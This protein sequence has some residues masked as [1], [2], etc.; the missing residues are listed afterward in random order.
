MREAIVAEAL[1]QCYAALSY[2]DGWTTA[3]D[4]L[5]WSVG[6][7]GC[8][9]VN[10]TSPA[11]RLHL[12]ASPRYQDFVRDFVAEGWAFSDHRAQR[13]WPKLR[14][15]GKVLIEHDISTE[16]ERDNLPVYR[17]LYARHDLYWWATVSFVVDTDLWAL[18]FLRSQAA[19]PF[20]RAEAEQ[21][22]ALAPDLSRLVRLQRA[23]T[24]RKARD[25][26]QTLDG[27]AC[28]A[29]VVGPDLAV[30]TLN[31]TAEA[32]LEP[33]L[34]VRG[35]RLIAGRPEVEAALRQLQSQ[36]RQDAVRHTAGPIVINRDGSGR[37]LLIDVV[38]GSAAFGPNAP[39]QHALLVMQD[40]D[41]K[42]EADGQRM[43]LI[44][45][46][47]RTEALCAE[48]L[49]YGD[50]IQAAADHLGIARETARSHLKVLFAKTGTNRQ[51]DL[52]SLLA[53]AGTYR[54]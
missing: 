19:E 8:S 21:L 33:D 7:Q 24:L 40:L 29:M 5:A 12:P 36:I 34:K 51:A 14:G 45:G 20:S 37:P 6:A 46:F 32:C 16:W 39:G 23:L 11:Q 50:T 10:Q 30:V 48:R 41:R 43:Q 35:G 44:F 47:T 9:F 31:R 54:R 38:P 17:D 25:L 15:G 2:E 53:Q 42:L 18:S 22:R 3:L 4:R 52:V 1:D 26:V 49:V 28:A 13:G 27:V